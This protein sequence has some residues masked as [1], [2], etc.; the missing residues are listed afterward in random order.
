MQIL[1]AEFG[2]T[3]WNSDEEDGFDPYWGVVNEADFTEAYIKKN[4]DFLARQLTPLLGRHAYK[5]GFLEKLASMAQV[6]LEGLT[7]PG[8]RTHKHRACVLWQQDARL[9][10]CACLDTACVLSWGGILK[11][12]CCCA[13][14]QALC[15]SDLRRMQAVGCGSSPH[16]R[17]QQTRSS[18]R[19]P[20]RISQRLRRWSQAC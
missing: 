4:A 7:Q 6:P 12:V 16:T 2:A 10:T 11:A 13:S 15:I 14:A 1:A 3:D 19:C 17:L 5:C 18:A 20:G 9:M 8:G